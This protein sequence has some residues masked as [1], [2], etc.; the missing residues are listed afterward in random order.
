MTRSKCRGAGVPE[1]R[2][3]VPMCLVLDV[4][5]RPRRHFAPSRRRAFVVVD[6][7]GSSGGQPRLG[8]LHERPPGSRR[9]WLGLDV[10]AQPQIRGMP[11]PALVG[12]LGEAHLRH[13]LGLHPVR[14]LVGHRRRH[15]EGRRLARKRRQQLRQPCQLD[16]GKPRADVPDVGEPAL[17]VVDAEQQGAEVR[18]VAARLGPA[19]DDELLRV[20]QFE[21]GPVGGPLAREV[22][23]R[24]PLG[25]QAFPAPRHRLAVQVAAV[26]AHLRR[27]AQQRRAGIAEDAFQRGA[28]RGQGQ[29][30]QVVGPS[31]SRSNA[32][33]ADGASSAGPMCLRLIRLCRC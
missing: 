6:C 7:G 12:P 25:D 11:Q 2:S 1:C 17:V 22:A 29:P 8:F 32:M 15:V 23:R 3:A 30:A 14:R 4:L 24:G 5:G 18:A 9:T 27:Q 13:Q 10:V 26:L 28:P 33:N 20:L 19:A 31:R 16:L 21:L